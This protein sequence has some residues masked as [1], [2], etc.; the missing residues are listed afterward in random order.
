[1]AILDFFKYQFKERYNADPHFADNLTFP[2]KTFEVKYNAILKERYPSITDEMKRQLWVN[3][4]IKLDIKN[5]DEV[6]DGVKDLIATNFEHVDLITEKNS[7]LVK[8]LT[9][10][11]TAKIY[12]VKKFSPTHYHYSTLGDKAVLSVKFDIK[13]N[14]FKTQT[15]VKYSQGFLSEMAFMYVT[16]A[17]T[18]QMVDAKLQFDK[19]AKQL[20]Y[21]LKKYFMLD[22]DQNKEQ[23]KP[24]EKEQKCLSGQSV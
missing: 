12:K 24:K 20:E 5:L 22:K 19:Q 23:E 2:Y 8:Y 4:K 6:T 10:K 16:Y 15:I 3:K 13:L 18:K 1:M 9:E 11:K 14:F 7:S 21:K 17:E